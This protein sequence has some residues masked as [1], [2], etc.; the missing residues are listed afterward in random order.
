MKAEV[1]LALALGILGL[2]LLEK[3][4]SSF[5]ESTHDALQK[6]ERK[7]I[8]KENSFNGGPSTLLSP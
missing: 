1:A 3:V 6:Y 8:W 4:A 7:W 5:H 2:G